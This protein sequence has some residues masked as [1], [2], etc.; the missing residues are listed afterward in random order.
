MTWFKGEFVCMYMRAC[1]CECVRCTYA[2]VFMHC[3]RSRTPSNDICVSFL[4]KERRY[5]F[6]HRWE[7][8]LTS[9]QRSV[10]HAAAVWRDG[11]CRELDEST[12]YVL[13]RSQLITVAQQMPGR[14]VVCVYV[15]VCVCV[16]EKVVEWDAGFCAQL[17][18]NI[19]THSHRHSQGP[20][21]PAR[22]QC[23]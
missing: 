15:C 23:L 7:L 5:I 13:P 4:L 2:T 8:S 10:L 20:V 16:C 11:V 22:P 19:H 21:A 9:L 12:G 18:T 17:H 1:V 6:T 3:V 14:V